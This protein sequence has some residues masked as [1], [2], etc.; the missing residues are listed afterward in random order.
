MALFTWAPDYNAQTDT[1]FALN[2]VKF[3]DGY[4]QRTAEGLNNEMT[5]MDVRFTRKRTEADAIEAFLRAHNAGQSF[6]FVPPGKADPVKVYVSEVRRTHAG[7]D[8]VEISCKF[9][10]VY[11]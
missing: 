2:V 9:E 1:K 11:E 3:G 7:Y 4:S 8:Q 5:T 6:E 10:R